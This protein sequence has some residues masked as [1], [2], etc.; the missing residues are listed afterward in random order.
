MVETMIRGAIAEPEIG[1]RGPLAGD[2]T[3]GRTFLVKGKVGEMT[4][5]YDYAV[6]VVGTQAFQ[7]VGF[8]RAEF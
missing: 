1:A 3:R 2:N 8:S 4:L 7:I 5:E 6:A